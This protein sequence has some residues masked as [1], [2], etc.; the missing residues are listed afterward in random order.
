VQGRTEKSTIITA[1]QLLEQSTSISDTKL[2]KI[3]SASTRDS[4]R[5]ACI[6]KAINA[7]KY[8]QFYQI[9][10]KFD[11]SSTL[12]EAITSTCDGSEEGRE[13][14]TLKMLFDEIR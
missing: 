6:S 8:N 14:L 13:C 9:L 3:T 2:D 12:G 5:E 1:Q 10:S 11:E 4:L 7:A